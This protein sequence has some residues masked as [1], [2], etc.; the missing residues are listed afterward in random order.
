M[1]RKSHPQLMRAWESLHN[2][3]LDLVL[4]G[5]GTLVAER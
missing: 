1:Q 4:P 3:S 5:L 2:P